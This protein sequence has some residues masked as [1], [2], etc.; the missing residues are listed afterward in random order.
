MPEE[1]IGED[2]KFAPP[3][4]ITYDEEPS[5]P[6]VGEDRGVGGVVEILKPKYGCGKGQRLKVIGETGSLLQF[7]GGKTAPK[8][9]EDKG[10]KWVLRE[11]EEGRITG[12]KIA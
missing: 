1:V 7:E 4:R 6:L 9:Q 5:G 12:A 3:P 2:S 10:W 8:N 11:E